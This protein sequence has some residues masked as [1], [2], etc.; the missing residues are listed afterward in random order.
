MDERRRYERHTLNLAVRYNSHADLEHRGQIENISLSGLLMR[1]H[2]QTQLGDTVIAYPEGLG[3]LTGT[4]VRRGPGTLALVF[5]L[6]PSA[7]QTLDKRIKS[8]KHG[9]C[10]SRLLDRRL[11]QRRQINLDSRGTH[12]ASGTEF[13]CRIINLTPSGAAVETR[14]PVNVGDIIA[15]GCLV[16]P[17]QRLLP[18][19]F[20]MAF[21]V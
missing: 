17:V 6:S 13:A 2:S 5:T 3:R 1:T 8:A 19:G 4:V 12:R 16:G 18:Y 15:I 7:R 14:L 11:H 20:A 9:T 10:Y 21:H